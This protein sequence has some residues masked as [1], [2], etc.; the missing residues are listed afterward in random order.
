FVDGVSILFH[1]VIHH[2]HS[3]I[4]A[5]LHGGH[6]LLQLLHLGLQL[7]HFLVGAKGRSCPYP[8]DQKQCH[9]RG[10]TVCFHSLFSLVHIFYMLRLYHSAGAIPQSERALGTG[11]FNASLG[12]GDSWS[13]WEGERGDAEAS[14]EMN[15][16]SGIR[17]DHGDSAASKLRCSLYRRASPSRS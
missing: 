6:L 9:E 16:T 11:R 8:K 7:H 13:R 14:P 17:N 3:L 10:N 1:Q 15:P 12:G 2:A 4:E 5:L